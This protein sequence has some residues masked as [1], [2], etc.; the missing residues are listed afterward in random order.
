MH[1][2]IYVFL[3]SFVVAL[4]FNIS[5]TPNIIFKKPDNKLKSATTPSLFGFSVNLRKNSILIGAPKSQSYLK[6]QINVTEPGVVFKCSVSDESSCQSFNFDDKD[7]DDE[8]DKYRK[9]K[10]NQLFG[11]SMDGFG[12]EQESF[13]ACAPKRITSFT[14]D[15]WYPKGICYSVDST[16]R[17]EPYRQQEFSLLETEAQFSQCGFSVNAIEEKKFIFGC[18]GMSRWEG[19]VIVFDEKY[20][21]FNFTDFSYNYGANYLG[22]AV[23]SGK[24]TTSKTSFVVS[25]PRLDYIG[26]V[27]IFDMDSKLSNKFKGTQFGEYYGYSILCEDF[28]GDFKTDLAI[29]APQYSKD[30]KY[31]HGAV[32]LYINKGS[33]RKTTKFVKFLEA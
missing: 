5:P 3:T 2:Q 22:Y 20:Y 26:E 29:S 6:S 32:Y 25:A 9:V 18:P 14:T 24:F 10:N 11:W 30:G 28:N 15:F 13:M 17:S 16:S 12:S 7:N 19:S 21:R 8:N 1:L 33:V 27:Y 31:D 23:S 4:S